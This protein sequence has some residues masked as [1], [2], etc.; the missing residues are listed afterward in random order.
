M[1]VSGLIKNFQKRRV[2]SGKSRKYISD[3]KEYGIYSLISKDPPIF[4]VSHWMNEDL[5]F[6][7][8]LERIFEHLKNRK[9]YFL[10]FWCWNIDEPERVQLVKHFE[11]LHQKKYSQHKFIHLCNTIRQKE[12]FNKNGLNAIFCSHNAFIDENI[13]KPI[14]DCA[15]KYDAI[16]DARFKD[17][18]RHNLATKIENLALIYA[19]NPTIDNPDYINKVKRQLSK[20]ALLNHPNS[21]PYRNL[22]S[23][24]VNRAL[25]ESRVGLCLSKIEGAMY[26]SIQYLLCG[27]PVVSTKS[28]GG[29]DV[30]FDNDYVMIVEDNAGAVKEGVQILIK[31]N[32]SSDIIRSKT[33]GKIIPH[34]NRFKSLIQNIYDTEDI[35][36]N[37]F[38]EWDSIFFNKLCKYQKHI[39]IIKQL[40]NNRKIKV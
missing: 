26:A 20:A 35:K 22:T 40:E 17:Y 12:E 1:R 3:N 36:R 38:E 8:S 25:N 18:K 30:F 21:E 23:E 9:A 14:S 6:S 32:L 13:F 28:L 16:Y 34:R 27:L 5:K 19:F 37:F 2:L 31:R 4:C 10:Y 11:N 33:I 24:E 29:R 39:D 7:H 15:K